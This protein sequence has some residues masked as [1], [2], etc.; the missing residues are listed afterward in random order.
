MPNHSASFDLG[1]N[2]R[3]RWR[4]SNSWRHKGCSWAKRKCPLLWS[5]DGQRR[6]E[7]SAH[8]F[9][10]K[11]SFEIKDQIFACEILDLGRE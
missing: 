8:I 3:S 1:K 9:A 2:L 10:Q 7:I 11:K 4:P 5:A 6:S